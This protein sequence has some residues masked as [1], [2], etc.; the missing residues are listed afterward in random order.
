MK[1]S[2]RRSLK[3]VLFLA[4]LSI[5]S[6]NVWAQ[7][8]DL[9]N[10]LTWSIE[11]ATLTISKTGEGSG[12]M[13]DYNW[14]D[15]SPNNY[16]NC[17][18]NDEK[19]SIT[20]VIIGEGVTGIGSLSIAACEYLESV[21]ISESVT[22]IGDEAFTMCGSLINIKLPSNLKTIGKLA[23]DACHSIEGEFL[24]PT[25][26]TD[27][28][29]RAFSFCDGITSYAVA[30]DNMHFKSI[31]GVL[32]TKDGSRLIMLPAGK[33]GAYI[34]PDGVK[35]ISSYAL[36][37]D[38][39]SGDVTIPESVTVIEPAAFY[40]CQGITGLN[41]PSSIESISNGAFINCSN[42]TFF[43]IDD[44]NEYYKSSEGVLFSKDGILIAYPSKKEGAYNIPDDVIKIG[45]YAFQDSKITGV[46]IPGSV[47]TIGSLAF[48]GCN[49]IISE[50]TI[51][52][53]VITIGNSAFSRCENLRCII[54]KN[55]TPPIIG[56]FVFGFG[57][58]IYIDNIHVPIGSEDAYKTALNW[59]DYAHLINGDET[60]LPQII[61]SLFT[62]Y[63]N[64]TTGPVT[65][66]GLTQGDIISVYNLSGA[67][68][69]TFAATGEAYMVIDLSNL[70]KGA[71]LLK[72]NT[73][74]FKVIKN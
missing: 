65:I 43:N 49:N 60:G 21:E 68:V 16:Y 39:L 56:S 66:S 73:R 72:S 25:G 11:G 70:A 26:V 71:Y 38:A 53:S 52:A 7:S 29:E 19:L 30:E 62:V 51:P 23:F 33:E 63:P 37:G 4:V 5:C 64:P 14:D 54:S 27:I 6:S 46:I 12:K 41:L 9:G 34:I 1:T 44:N 50:I 58:S 45:D 67:L 35:I 74:S 10:G 61:T 47:T 40:N 42:I 24:I 59:S 22:S 31:E 18:W 69:G 48:S 13:P 3:A 32:F 36:S 55:P 57:Q 8:G 17:P 20:K 28:G 2:F 15:D